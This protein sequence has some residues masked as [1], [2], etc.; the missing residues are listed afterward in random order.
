[1][2]NLNPPI[3]VAVQE[4]TFNITAT[5]LGKGS[6]STVRKALYGKMDVAAKLLDLPFYSSQYETEAKVLSSVSHFNIIRLHGSREIRTFDKQK[7]VLFLDLLNKETNPTLETF[8]HKK[9]IFSE[10]NALQILS[11]LADALSHLHSRGYAHRDI[12]P[13]N[14]CIRLGD[15]QP[16][17]FDFGY[18]YIL[19]PHKHQRDNSDETSTNNNNNNNESNDVRT[20]IEETEQVGTPLFMSPEVLLEKPYNPFAVD[21]WGLGLIFYG[22]L[23]GET[24]TAGLTDY[25]A[26]VQMMKNTTSFCLDK[27]QTTSVRELLAGML[28]FDPKERLSIE[29]VKVRL[30]TCLS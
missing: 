3:P 23:F 12:K 14:C 29:E 11:R 24:P 8:I 27:C 9:Q 5:R 18:A 30:V 28:A 1:M 17:L 10:R 20:G 15:L 21:V 7:G 2:Y 13:S 16:V 6:T 25:D 22:M 4:R 19:D 26:L